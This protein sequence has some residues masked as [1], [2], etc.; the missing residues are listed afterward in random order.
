MR[1]FD[2]SVFLMQGAGAAAF[3]DWEPEMPAAPFSFAAFSF[4]GRGTLPGAAVYTGPRS[5][6]DPG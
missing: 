4:Q 2:Y 6:E 1:G 3:R 5:R